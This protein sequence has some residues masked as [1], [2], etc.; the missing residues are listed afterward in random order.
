[1]AKIYET[2]EDFEKDV[3][4]NQAKDLRLEAS[5]QVSTGFFLSGAGLFTDILRLRKVIDNR[6]GLLSQAFSVIGLID[7]V[8]SF[9]TDHK[10]RDLELQRQRMGPETIVIPPDALQ[11]ELKTDGIDPSCGCPL[12]RYSS[13]LA[14]TSLIEQAMKGDSTPTRE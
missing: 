4:K 9:F 8:R 11:Q 3:I 13:A 10:A 1:M 6:W 12:K 2:K 7:I 14:P 5:R